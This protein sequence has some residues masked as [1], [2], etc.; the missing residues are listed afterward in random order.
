[1]TKKK[2]IITY[3]LITIIGLLGVLFTIYALMPV[4]KNYVE[5][6]WGIEVDNSE[7]C[8]KEAENV[9]IGEVLKKVGNT[10]S[11]FMPENQFEV[12]VEESIK[13]NLQGNVIVNQSGGYNIF[14]KTI[15]LYDGDTL[16]EE[17]ETY[18]FTTT[19]ISEY[20]KSRGWQQVTPIGGKIKVKDEEHKK[21]LI[22][23][24]KKII[25]IN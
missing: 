14:T 24:F 21:E 9:F 7:E 25:N 5:A 3:L 20:N 19:A 10:I 6:F 22:E 12:H 11:T 16:I 8:A 4:R 2:R 1:M 23:R 18:L 17:G 13:G 15:V